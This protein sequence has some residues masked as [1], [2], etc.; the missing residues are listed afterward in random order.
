M[1]SGSLVN[2]G[3]PTSFAREFGLKTSGRT[4]SIMSNARRGG[5]N[6]Q[7]WKPNMTMTSKLQQYVGPLSSAEIAEGMNAASQKAERLA[8][9]ARP[10][11]ENERLCQF[12]LAGCPVHRRV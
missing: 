9:D 10:L 4:G 5:W 11:F 8:K 1:H 7:S 6:N 3:K 12:A 2:C